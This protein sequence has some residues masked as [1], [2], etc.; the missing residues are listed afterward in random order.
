MVDDLRD[1]RQEAATRRGTRGRLELWLRTVAD[2]LWRAPV[3][4]ADV[5]RRDAAYAIRILRRRP[6]STATVIASI[7]IGIGL[8]TT[9]FTIVS[10]VLWQSLPFPEAERLV[11]IVEFDPGSQRT[12]YLT[13]GDF[14]DLHDATRSFSSLGGGS[15]AVQTIVEPG[16]PE[17]LAG[18]MV[19]ADY[20]ETLAARPVVGRIFADA[21]Y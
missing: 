14:G 1:Q 18:M 19:G 7:A 8:T 9:L 13:N 16:E 10:A 6:A 5:L 12:A 4:H 3:E 15:Y 17:E 11:R 2:V 21:E 20:F